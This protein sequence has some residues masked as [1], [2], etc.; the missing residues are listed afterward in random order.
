MATPD[1]DGTLSEGVVVEAD[2]SAS[3]LGL[4]LLRVRA[5]VVLVPARVE[6][7]SALEGQV[8]TSRPQASNG[9]H[10]VTRGDRT[11]VLAEA[12]RLVTES[13]RTL[14]RLRQQDL[15]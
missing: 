7:R 6:G 5:D 13:G 9:A 1:S 8:V 4:R 10:R 15:A 3:L 11:G 2:V 12:T 14:D